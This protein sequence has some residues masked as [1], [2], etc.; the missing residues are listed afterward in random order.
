MGGQDFVLNLGI[1]QSLNKFHSLSALCGQ[2]LSYST[3]RELSRSKSLIYCSRSS[4]GIPV[5]I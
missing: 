5:L 1:F 4:R 2:W 3:L